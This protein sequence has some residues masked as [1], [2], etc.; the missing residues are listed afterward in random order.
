MLGRPALD[1]ALLM[2]PTSA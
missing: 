1:T 2:C